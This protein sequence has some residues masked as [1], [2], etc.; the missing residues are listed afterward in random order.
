MTENDRSKVLA[1]IAGIQSVAER[2]NNRERR[3][4]DFLVMPEY[5]RLREPDR[6]LILGGRGAGKTRVFRVLT[7]TPDGFAKIIGEQRTIVGPNADNTHVLTGYNVHRDFPASSILDSCADDKNARAYW[8]G[9]LLLVLMHK[10]PENLG[11]REI[12]L[13]YLNPDAVAQF[14]SFESVKRPKQWLSYIQENPE[15]WE[16]ILDE[17]DEQL[18]RQNRWI[19]VAYDALD[20][21]A[22]QYS[23]LFPFLRNLLSF[24]YTHSRR[25]QRL[26]C[27]IFLR[28]D[29]YQSQLLSFTD[30]SK[31]SNC[32]INL[33]WNT[34]SLYRLLIKRIANAGS[35][36]AVA[37]LN[38]IPQ[39]I[40][41]DLDPALGYIPTEKK[42]KI[43]K[44]VE[45]LLG[46]YMGNSPKQGRSYSWVPNHLQDANG[47]LSPRPFLKCFSIAAQGMCEHPEEREKLKEPQLISPTRIQGALVAVSDDRVKELQEE[48][49]WL[50]ELKGAFSGLTMLMDQQV[51]IE[52]I[53]MDLWDEDRKKILPERSPQGIFSVL[54][55]LGIVMIASDGRVNVPE[56]YLHGFRM[57][58]KG[59]L[60]RPTE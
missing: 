36:E 5:S 19:F 18:E 1:A 38:Q 30:S 11:L 37:Y 13:Q 48:Y 42:D 35:P 54:K 43:Q 50:E 51:F 16:N 29:L 10:A 33:V 41:A 12:V 58:R 60:R 23:D 46:I 52:R 20:C 3:L 53:N 17:M 24:W 14:R 55:N 39:L 59:G 49:S 44:F 2:E 6:F 26:H 4:E 9:S 21:V 40:R 7:E 32:I 47:V 8:A 25:W 45:T 34:T 22:S 15:V 56:I 57:K 28:N 31:L 27:K